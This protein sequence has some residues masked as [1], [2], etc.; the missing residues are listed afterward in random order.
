MARPTSTELPSFTRRLFGQK[1]AVAEDRTSDEQ[2]KA[3]N[4]ERRGRSHDRAPDE[5][6]HRSSWKVTLSPDGIEMRA[7]SGSLA[8]PPV[9]G[10]A[11]S[12]APRS[13]RSSR[14]REDKGWRRAR[15]SPRLAPIR[16]SSVRS[17]RVRRVERTTRSDREGT[18]PR[19]ARGPSAEADSSPTLRPARALGRELRGR[20]VVE[21][22][23]G[24][25]RVDHR[26][27]RPAVDLGFHVELAAPLLAHVLVH[28]LPPELRPTPATWSSPR[29]S[30]TSRRSSMPATSR[31]PRAI[32]PGW[33]R[34]VGVHQDLLR[35]RRLHLGCGVTREKRRGRH[36]DPFSKIGGRRSDAP[37]K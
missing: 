23:V 30:A 32:E 18:T 24:V 29:P 16:P 25:E 37:G 20:V 8:Y 11:R 31:V 34:R 5:R 22:I 1:S 6:G 4:Q 19:N 7:A 2:P 3:A 35:G 21:P 13:A 27:H 10:A 33:D 9:T 36:V 14:T 15:S 12:K 28:E 17:E 26:V